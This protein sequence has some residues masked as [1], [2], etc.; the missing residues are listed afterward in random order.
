MRSS[1]A[2]P[3]WRGR[4]LRVYLTSAVWNMGHRRLFGA[5]SRLWHSVVMLLRVGTA[6]FARDF[7]RAVSQPYASWTFER[8]LQES[9]RASELDLG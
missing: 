4:M 7:W 8:G 5:A 2:D 6:V 1:A 9:R 3:F